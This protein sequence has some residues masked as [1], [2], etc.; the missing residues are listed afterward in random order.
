MKFIKL[1]TIL[2]LFLLITC[3]LKPV[4][5][6]RDNITFEKIPSLYEGVP[7]F[8]DSLVPKFIV[9]LKPL[10]YP[11][12]ARKSETTGIVYCQALIDEY[13]EVEAIYINKSLS[14]VCNIACVE[15]IKKSKFKTFQQVTGGNGKYSLLIPFT[16][17]I[18]TENKIRRRF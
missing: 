1:I 4:Y 7:A 6:S 2:S 16:F 3:A 8:K 17:N 15:A 18:Y 10:E 12:S 11:E 9:K 14:Y 13:G 5:Y